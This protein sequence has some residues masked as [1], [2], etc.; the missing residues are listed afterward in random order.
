MKALKKLLVYT[1]VASMTL[2]S[3]AFADTVSSNDAEYED[4]IQESQPEEI[5][6]EQDIEK[7]IVTEVS[8]NEYALQALSDLDLG[9]LSDEELNEYFLMMEGDVLYAFLNTL[10]EEELDQLLSRN[11]ILSSYTNVLV[12]NG[13][14]TDQQM[15]YYDMLKY[16]YGNLKIGT[17]TYTT[18]GTYRFKL[19]DNILPNTL[20]INGTGTCDPSSPGSGRVNTFS[21]TYT[22]HNG[23]TSSSHDIQIMRNSQVFTIG[24]FSVSEPSSLSGQNDLSYRLNVSGH[25]YR[26]YLEYGGSCSGTVCNIEGIWSRSATNNSNQTKYIIFSPYNF[27][28]QNY[29]NSVIDGQ[30]P[31]CT[32]DPFI[33]STTQYFNSPTKGSTKKIYFSDENGNVLSTKQN[34]YTYSL[35][36]IDIVS[37]YDNSIYASYTSETSAIIHSMISHD[38]NFSYNESYK[39]GILRRKYTET[40]NTFSAPAAP[41]KTGYTFS[42]WKTSSGKTFDYANAVSG[43]TY[44]ATYTPNKYTITYNANGGSVSP[45]SASVTYDSTCPTAPTPTRGGYTFT[46]W[47]GGTYSGTYKTA[48]NT[49]VIAGWS[50]ITYNITYTLNG[51]TASNPKTYT[52]ETPTFTLNNPTRTGYTFTGWTGT[53]ITTPTTSVT[54][55]KGST[56]GNRAYTANWS[57]NQYTIKFN[58][59]GGTASTTEKKATYDQTIGTLPTAVKTGY[60][61]TGWIVNGS[62]ITSSSKNLAASGTVNASANYTENSYTAKFDTDGGNSIG[63]KTVKY[64]ENISFAT[65]TKTNYTFKEWTLNG[66]SIGTQRNKFSATNGAAVTFKATYTPYQHTIKFDTTLKNIDPMQVSYG[67][68][69]TLPTVSKQGY[70]FAGWKS[71]SVTSKTASNSMLTGKANNSTI[72]VTPVFT[73]NT[74]TPYSVNYYYQPNFNT[75]NRDYYKLSDTVNKTGTTDAQV[76]VEPT[77]NVL[78]KTPENKTITVGADG[79]TVVSFY[80]DLVSKLSSDPGVYE[81]QKAEIKRLIS[82]GIIDKS[83]EDALLNQSSGSDPDDQDDP[84]DPIGPPVARYI[85]NIRYYYKASDDVTILLDT[86]QDAVDSGTLYTVPDLDNYESII[87]SRCNDKNISIRKPQLNAIQI[88]KDSDIDYIYL[89]SQLGQVDTKTNDPSDKPNNQPDASEDSKNEPGKDD[90]DVPTTTPS[91][92]P[93]D[94]DYA[95]QLS[96][97]EEMLKSQIITNEEYKAIIAELSKNQSSLLSL[98][99]LLDKGELTQKQIEEIIQKLKDGDK[100]SIPTGHG[101]IEVQSKPDGTAS[102]TGASDKDKR[103]IIPNTIS[104]GS[105]IYVIREI[106]KNAFKNNKTVEN[107]EVPYGVAKIKESAFEGCTKLK[108]VKLP[109]TVT[110]IA[111]KS[112][113][114][115]KSLKKIVIPKSVTKIGKNAYKNCKSAKNII[116]DSTGMLTSIGNSAFEGCV[117]VSRVVLPENL[118]TIGKKAFYGCKKLKNV[119]IK[120]D[121]LKKVGSKAFKKCKKKLTFACPKR[122]LSKYK[123]LLKGKY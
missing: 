62:V 1:L 85:V 40:E 15:L 91:T 48:G 61:F 33:T 117:K 122:K 100:V 78:F 113:S 107:V 9:S 4:V 34:S 75:S 74:N 30:S 64:T 2:Q 17:E 3:V 79:K 56:T 109:E 119:N 104:A 97:L 22:D 89:V 25:Q 102:V 53:K 41:A 27:Y 7:P 115:C 65:P 110:E 72:T 88:Q 20:I 6:Q 16:T 69:T 13:Q 106:E 44:L 87:Q 8:G 99:S 114:G 52:V 116:F 21:V 23:R 76:I 31:V 77:Q 86:V 68:N 12:L 47:S 18:S 46:G 118:K 82:A 14:K 70:T 101:T 43:E 35:N 108:D 24:S 50:P 81:E 67:A 84:D 49:T 10:E 60:T 36:G 26:T 42:A 58:A 73:A 45:S 103:I 5:T 38:P 54:I 94:S 92:S 29:V 93:S 95:K 105:E 55:S 83:V 39:P 80:M 57:A 71:G 63:D 121:I 19:D 111:N 98:S 66:K 11:T 28:I 37:P 112:F 32:Y 123:K 59:N 51:G 90:K 120:T 96:K